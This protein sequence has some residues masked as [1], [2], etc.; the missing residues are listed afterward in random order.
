MIRN[1]KND[2]P[3][4]KLVSLIRD[5]RASI[6]SLTYEYV[7]RNGN[8][9]GFR[10]GNI[11]SLLKLLFKGHFARDKPFV[12]GF[13]ILYH[14]NVYSQLNKL[15]SNYPNMIII[16]NEDI[17]TNFIGSLRIIC[18]KLNVGFSNSW[19]RNDYK[20]TFMKSPWQ[21]NSKISNID[22][23]K[24]TPNILMNNRWI[25][26]LN[27]HS[28]VTIEWLL[29]KPLI[30]Y[31]YKLKFPQLKYYTLKF[32]YHFF[33]NLYMDFYF[34]GNRAN[35]LLNYFDRLLFLILSPLLY[36]FSRISLLY[37]LIFAKL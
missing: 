30:K 17:N 10:S 9:Y 12:F 31:D 25:N 4:C 19:M 8:P 24:T 13:W 7:S 28:I 2:F 26:K 1:A 36:I 16:R 11:L 5:P 27:E 3:N 6:T 20:P 15:R 37:N 18:K 33:L 35:I 22:Y 32:A 29:Q 21:I 34:E 23:E 14:K